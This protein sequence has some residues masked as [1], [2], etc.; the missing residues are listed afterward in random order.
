MSQADSVVSTQQN[1]ITGH[2]VILQILSKKL[3]MSKGPT[4]LPRVEHLWGPQI[5]YQADIMEC[6]EKRRAILLPNRPNKNGSKV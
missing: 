4:R 5:L 3:T 6:I 1:S 2:F